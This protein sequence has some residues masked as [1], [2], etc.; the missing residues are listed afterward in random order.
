M[1]SRTSSATISDCIARVERR[2]LKEPKTVTSH[3]IAETEQELGAARLVE[4]AHKLLYEGGL[5]GELS[6]DEALP[7]SVVVRDMEAGR[8]LHIG[9]REGQQGET[10]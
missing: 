3:A 7:A 4:S 2:K 1:P 6:E 9:P 5:S 10:G 8:E